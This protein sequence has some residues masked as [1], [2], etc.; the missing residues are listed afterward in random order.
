VDINVN[1][2]RRVNEFKDKI[3]S[4][5][6]IKTIPKKIKAACAT[7]E[8]YTDIII[9]NPKAIK[10]NPEVISSSKAMVKKLKNMIALKSKYLLE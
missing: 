5:I 9:A 1:S 2:S 6:E 3:D 4:F 8:K 10:D 7:L